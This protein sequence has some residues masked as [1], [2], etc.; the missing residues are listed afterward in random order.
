MFS[1]SPHLQ[2]PF[3]PSAAFVSSKFLLKTDPVHVSAGHANH[4]KSLLNVLNSERS[5]PC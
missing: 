3:L 1:N 5:V 2:A 4:A